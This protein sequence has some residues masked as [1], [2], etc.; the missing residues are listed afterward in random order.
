[1]AVPRIPNPKNVVLNA[2][3]TLVIDGVKMPRWL[4][5]DSMLVHAPRTKQES[6]TI[7]LKALTPRRVSMDPPVGQLAWLN[8]RGQK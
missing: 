5:A 6:Y 8:S 4:V 2:D 7:M 1:M 3:G